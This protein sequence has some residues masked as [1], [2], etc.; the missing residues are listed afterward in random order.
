MNV[1]TSR[2]GVILWLVNE[3]A[4]KR[5]YLGLERFNRKPSTT[6]M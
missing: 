2:R 3:R 6:H 4:L 1:Y 5:D